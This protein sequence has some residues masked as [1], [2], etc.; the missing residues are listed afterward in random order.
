MPNKEK[1]QKYKAKDQEYKKRNREKYRLYLISWRASNTDKV[2]SYG[3]KYYEKGKVISTEKCYH[4]KNKY[5][6]N[7]MIKI[8]NEFICLNCIKKSITKVK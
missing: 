8:V 2:K 4:C 5:V 7:L 1:Y 6:R 3:K